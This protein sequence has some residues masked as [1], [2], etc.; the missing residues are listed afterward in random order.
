MKTRT[1]WVAAVGIAL[2]TGGVLVASRLRQRDQL[3]QGLE[4]RFMSV[5]E[6][7]DRVKQALAE[8][9]NPQAAG[10]LAKAA[11]AFDEAKELFREGHVK[12]ARTALKL[13]GQLAQRAQ[14]LCGAQ[15]RQNQFL[16]SLN[17]RADQLEEKAR[18]RNNR[19]ALDLI[20]R[21]RGILSDAEG[22]INDGLNDA[23]AGQLKAAE[24]LLRQAKRLLTR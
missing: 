20:G 1:L 22:L 23:A 19:E 16:Q 18:D 5:Q 10:V 17:T 12:Q 13:A 8:C 11:S 4:R 2:L 21:A 3:E 14:G 9:E 7:I 6:L 15:D 24:L